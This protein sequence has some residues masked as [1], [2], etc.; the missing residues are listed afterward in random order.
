MNKVYPLDM[1]NAY[2]GKPLAA[3][4]EESAQAS[5]VGL[6]R[7][8]R[9][10][11]RMMLAVFLLTFAAV[12]IFTFQLTPVYSAASSVVV[13]TRDQRVID[14]GAVVS[15]LPADTAMLDTEVEILRSRSLIGKVV[16]RL[17]LVENPEFNPNKVKLTGTDKN[18]AGFKTFVSGLFGLNPKDSAR[19]L[20]PEEIAEAEESE[21]AWVV[22]NVQSALTVN[23]VGVTYIVEIYAKSKDRKMAAALANT[24]ADVYLSNQLDQKFEATRRAQEWLNSNA[25]D[26]RKEVREAESKVSEHM[27]RTGLTTA[28]GSTLVEQQIRDVNAELTTATAELA[29]K[30]ARLQNVQ[31]RVAQGANVDTIAEALSSVNIS[32]L[33]RQQAEVQRRKA[34][35][36]QKYLPSHPDVQKVNSEL[37]DLNRQ[38][39]AELRRIVSSLEQ[40]VV[41]AREE[42]AAHQSALNRL[43]GELSGNSVDAV[44][45]AELQREADASRK[46]LEEFVSRSKETSQLEDITTADAMINARAPVPGEPSFPNVPLSLALGFLL[47]AAFAGLAGLLAE[48]LDNYISTAEEAEALTGM[49]Y[50]GHVPLLHASNSFVKDKVSP[51]DYLVEKPHSAFAE[52][53]RHMRASIMFADLDKAAKTVAIVSSLPDEGKTS[54]TFCLGRISAMSGTKTIV[55]D[56]DLRRRQLTEVSGQD[57][58]SGLLEYLFGE[59]RL[60]D[61]IR[62]DAATGLHIMPLSNRRHTPR[63]VFGSRAFDALLAMLQ[64]SYDLIIIDTGPIMLMAETRVVTS[65]VDQVVL[66]ARWRKTPKGVLRDTV[67]TLRDFHANVTGVVLTFVDLRKKAHHSYSAAAYKGYNKYYSPE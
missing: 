62:T 22:S 48:L 35:L 39:D 59:A 9:R 8:L 47:G 61:V 1:A 12:A 58:E 37:A 53:F 57:H 34:E 7:A 63:D 41:I 24:V 31:N 28:A 20:T 42:V 38:V 25:D 13:N 15:G 26:L 33:R 43:K 36:E 21:F 66:A 49:P 65:K 18:I 11:S 14:I 56:G 50:I 27:S 19:A 45:A 5:L 40:D 23:R 32:D 67:K 64:Q 55:I 30:R 46:L 17:N 52:A 6:F 2:P 16:S 60:A 3:E 4:P 10:R 29:Q 51:A 54:V 44:R